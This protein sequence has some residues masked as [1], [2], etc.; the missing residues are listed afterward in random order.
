MGGVLV[1]EI[2][3][4]HRWAPYGLSLSFVRQEDIALH[5]VMQLV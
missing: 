3:L 1:T 2:L 4:A 5:A